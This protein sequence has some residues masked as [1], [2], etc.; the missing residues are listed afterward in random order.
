M[1]E[2]ERFPMVLLLAGLLS[3]GGVAGETRFRISYPGSVHEGPLTGRAYVMISRTNEREPRLQIGRTGVPFF[4][5]DFENLAPGESVAIDEFDLGSPVPSLAEIPPGEYFV[6]AF[7]NI[8]VEFRRADGHVVW[9]HDDRWEGQQWERSP[10]NL[11]SEVLALELDAKAG[12]VHDLSVDRVLPPIDLPEDTPWVKRFR[13][14]SPK[15]TAFWGKPIYLG[16]TV[17]LPRDYER[18]TIRYP[19][20]YVQGHFSIA[21]PMS[22]REGEDFHR[23]WI[24]DRFPRMIVVTF[25][26]PNPYFDTSYSVNSVNVGPYGDALLE[27]LIPEVET[28]FR[29]IREPYARVLTGGSTGGWEALALQIFH[30]DFFGGTFA[31][32]PDPVT[33]TNVEGIDI[34]EDTNAFYKQHEWRR[35]PIANSRELTGEVRLTSEQRNHFELVAGTR[36]RSGEQFDVWSAVFGPLGKDGYFEPLFDKRTGAMNRA[37]AEHWREHYDL[38]HHLKQNWATL[39]PK[40]VS[41]IHVYCGDMDDFYLNVAVKELELFLKSTENPHYPG[42]FIWGDGRGHRFGREFST[43]A[44]RIRRMAEHV[45]AVRPEGEPHPWWDFAAGLE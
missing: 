33:F 5:V 45:L 16:A 27:E 11:T 23:A 10:G 20:V 24:S 15:L 26:D 32:A 22:F 39:G 38:L 3:A 4:G 18:E 7:L 13:F 6:Q 43:E 29:V 40:L 9:M 41:K 28:R 14:E 34:Y 35:V 2:K 42:V 8:Y 1:L 37:V 17:L 19:V 36:G 30:P 12:Y 31:Y 44:E 25:Q 21:D